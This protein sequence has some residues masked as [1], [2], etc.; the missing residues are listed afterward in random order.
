MQDWLYEVRN[1]NN[2]KNRKHD[3]ILILPEAKKIVY[4]ILFNFKN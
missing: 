1:R 3:T 2:T 4:S